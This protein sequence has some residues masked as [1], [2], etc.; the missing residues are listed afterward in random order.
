M[1]APNR[2]FRARQRAGASLESPGALIAED[3]AKSGA[4]F[5]EELR[6]CFIMSLPCLKGEIPDEIRTSL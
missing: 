3:T 2:G 5:E 6:W 1:R 4:A